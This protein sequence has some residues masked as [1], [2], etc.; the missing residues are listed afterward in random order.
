MS[1]IPSDIAPA[2]TAAAPVP[3]S[4]DDFITAVFGVDISEV[5]RWWCRSPATPA[6]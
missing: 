4:N 6:R 2:H 5:R 1:A 3:I